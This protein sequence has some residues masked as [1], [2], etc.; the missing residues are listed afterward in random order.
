[1]RTGQLLSELKTIS[2]QSI[3]EKNYKN[4]KFLLLFNNNF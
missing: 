4:F 3:F 2:H 1:M